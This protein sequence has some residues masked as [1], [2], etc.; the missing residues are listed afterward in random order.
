MELSL[1][2]VQRATGASVLN[3]QP[4]STLE[5]LRVRGWSIDSRSIEPGDLFFAIKGDRYDGHAFV[6]AAL[7][8]GAVAAL[9]DQPLD[10]VAGPL[11]RV[12]D[13]LVALQKVAHWARQQWDGPMVAVTGSAG[14]TTT[15]DII[16]E[17]LSTRLRVGKTI[18]NFNN[19]IGLPLTLLRMPEDAQVG[20]IEIGMNH[21]GEI[22]RLAEI[23][24]PRI[25]VVTTVGHAHVEAFDSIDGVAAAKR[26]LIESLPPSGVAVLNAEDKRVLAF[27]DWHTGRTLTYGFSEKADVRAVNLNFHPEGASFTVCGVPFETR[28]IGRHAILNILAGLTV[29]TLFEFDLRELVA[30]VASL[31]SGKMRGER[32]RWRDITVLNDCYNS[33]PEAVRAMIDV[34]LE[35]PARRRIAVLSEML[36]LG[37]LT[38]K[39]HRQL[40]VYVAN[41]GVDVLVGVRGVSRFMVDEAVKAGLSDHAAFFFDQPEAAGAFL[42]HF[43]RPGDAILFKGSRATQ[44]EK[45]LATMEA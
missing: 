8:Q 18:G 26:E 7:E 32:S 39:L 30:A 13:N 11:L 29:A 5:N 22:R 42:R 38:E 24:E 31:A 17:L 33:N 23:A 41:A 25:G 37:R 20:V 21:A 44:L 1:D 19:H 9:I 16:A 36:E 27:R 14:K 15:K 12:A 4:F 2:Q 43:V 34:L 45:A 28:L 3:L 10:T 6:H 35:Q 40:G